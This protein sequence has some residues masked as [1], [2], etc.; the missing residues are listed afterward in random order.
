[1]D[2]CLIRSAKMNEGPRI[3]AV[4]LRSKAHWGYSQDFLDACV[5]DLTIDEAYI[6]L[7]PVFVAEW[8]NRIIGFYSIVRE[9]DGEYLDNMFIL[10]EYMGKGLGKTLWDHA[11][12]EFLKRK[13]HTFKLVADPFACGFYQK[14][15][16]VQM[17]EKESSTFPGRKL[18]VMIYTVDKKYEFCES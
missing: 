14:M 2:G 12:M 17:N 16:A 4:A 10:P 7:N 3:T 11:V 1:M 6:R 15:G 8:H 18:P 13:V 9:S 5:P